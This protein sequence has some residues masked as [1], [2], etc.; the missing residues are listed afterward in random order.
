MD[1]AHP[2]RVV[3]PTLVGDVLAVLARSDEE[4]SGRRI[5]R[6]L[7]HSSEPGVRKAAERLVDQS[8]VLRRQAWRANLYRLNRSHLAAPHIEALATLRLY[9]FPVFKG[10]SRLEVAASFVLLFGSVARGE[11]GAGA[12]STF[13]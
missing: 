3:T 5:H 10:H 1:F 11:G 4:F 7:G 2:L 13:S 12:I 8:I 6:L 9:L